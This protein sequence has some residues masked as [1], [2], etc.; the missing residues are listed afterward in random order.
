[1]KDV[2]KVKLAYIIKLTEYNKKVEKV[3]ARK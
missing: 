3:K 2:K 1:M